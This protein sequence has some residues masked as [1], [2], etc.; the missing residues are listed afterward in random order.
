M[1]LNEEEKKDIFFI[2]IYYFFNFSIFDYYNNLQPSKWM[3]FKN[4]DNPKV[5]V[6]NIFSSK[7]GFHHSYKV[8]KT[9]L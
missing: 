2:L 6:K 8:H 1:F 7:Y 9:T 5:A 4:W 3:T